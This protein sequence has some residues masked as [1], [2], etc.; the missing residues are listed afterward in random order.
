VGDAVRDYPRLTASRPGEDEHRAVA[1]Q[2]GSELWRIQSL[3]DGGQSGGRGVTGHARSLPFR[4]GYAKGGEPLPQD[5]FTLRFRGFLARA[6]LDPEPV[7]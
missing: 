7:I 2:D 6:I 5:C 4:A 3:N 1:V